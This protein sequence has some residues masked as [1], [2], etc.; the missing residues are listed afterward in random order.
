M[1]NSA[2]Y[3][4]GSVLFVIVSIFLILRA[5]MASGVDS[6]LLQEAARETGAEWVDKPLIADLDDLSELEGAAWQGEKPVLGK[7][8][9]SPASILL[10]SFWASYCLPCTREWPSMLG[11][12]RALGTQNMQMVAVSYD[13]S[14]EPMRS[15]FMKTTG[16]MPDADE[17]VV[18]RDGKTADE[19]MFKTRYGTDKIPETYVVANG[20]VLFRFVNERDWLDPRMRRFFER[21]LDVT[22]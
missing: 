18:L 5:G 14:W 7:V 19:E 10:V 15:F 20:R 3:A 4:I 22:R 21:L 12:V 2:P 16:E 1:S 11:L 8:S 6:Q 9:E 17:V 13:E